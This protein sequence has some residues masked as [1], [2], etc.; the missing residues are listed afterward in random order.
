MVKEVRF[1]LPDA[2][3]RKIKLL[4]MYQGKDMKV[5]IPELL[6]KAMSSCEVTVTIEGAP[7]KP[8]G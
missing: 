6:E 2:L 7:P 5:V 4:A 3:H 8:S 1:Q